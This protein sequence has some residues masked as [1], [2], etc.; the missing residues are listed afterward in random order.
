MG[1]GQELLSWYVGEHGF[2][3]QFC[4]KCGSTLCCNFEGRTHGITLGCLNEDLEIEIVK[5]IIV[6]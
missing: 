1:K 2:G 5:H 6:G 4:S 3:L